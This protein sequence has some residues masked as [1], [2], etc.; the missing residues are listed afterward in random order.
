MPETRLN[1]N[2]YVRDCVHN[3]VCVL[4]RLETPMFLAVVHRHH[5]VVEFLC[6]RGATVTGHTA[7]EPLDPKLLPNL[8]TALQ[9]V[10][11]DGQLGLVR[12]LLKESPGGA[13]LQSLKVRGVVVHMRL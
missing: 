2:V 13:A 5:N 7:P 8:R 9:R 12:G 3:C 11:A 4:Q 6:Q 1:D 10:C